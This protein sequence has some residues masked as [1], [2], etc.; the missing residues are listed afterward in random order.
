MGYGPARS[1]AAA[2]A[3]PCRRS[4]VVEQLFRKQQVRGSN[5]RAGSRILNLETAPKTRRIPSTRTR[6]RQ[7][8]VNRL[9]PRRRRLAVSVEQARQ[10]LDR[11]SATPMVLRVTPCP[12]SAWISRR[13]FPCSCKPGPVGD[14][15]LMEL[16]TPEPRVFE[17]P[18]Q[19]PP[20]VELA[21]RAA[22]AVGAAPDHGVEVAR[23]IVEPEPR[24]PTSCSTDETL[25]FC[26]YE[27]GKRA[28]YDLRRV[29]HQE[30]AGLGERL[31]LGVGHERLELLSTRERDPGVL[32]APE[33][34]HWDL[35]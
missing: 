28:R 32:L 6:W 15:Q 18:A 29:V 7:F 33:Y 1:P 12:I 23:A 10:P 2:R 22:Q 34:E 3:P 30:M 20:H 21:G 24:P 11:P 4:S 8:G 19:R 9:G 13:S 17:R 27:C 31:E 26:V 25:P 14:A 35:D 16:E 5:P